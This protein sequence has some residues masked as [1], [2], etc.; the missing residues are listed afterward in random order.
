M[1]TLDMRAAE[2]PLPV[3]ASCRACGSAD[4]RSFF[5]SPAIPVNNAR[6]FEERADALRVPNGALELAFC[7]ACGF[8]QNPRFD[9]ALVRYD[10]SYEEQQS[11]SPTF[12]AFADGLV[13][14]IIERFGLQGKRVVEIGCGKGDFLVAICERGGNAGLGL[15]PTIAPDRL[16]QRTGTQLTLRREFFGE[17]TGLL[18]ADAVICR[19]TLEHIADVRGFVRAL[20]ASLAGSPHARI[21]FE[22]PDVGRVLRE[23]AFW[24]VYYE[25]CSYFT[26]D[27]LARLFRENGFT[28]DDAWLA[29]GDQYVMLEARINPDGAAPAGGSEADAEALAALTASYA[30]RVSAEMGRWSNTIRAAKDA[31]ERV[32]VWGS[33][34]KCVAFLSETGTAELVDAVVDINPHRQGRFLPSTG[35][36]VR[37]PESL[38]AAPPDLVVVMNEAYVSEITAQ[39]ASMGLKPQ[40]EAVG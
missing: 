5:S 24:D 21:F 33:G 6:V 4:L 38:T 20:R 11:F 36:Q 40:V 10:D 39:L 1:N 2:S 17:E 7:R 30:E 12:T 35:I 34:S 14:D 27:S 19:H 26:T 16:R 13:D 29:F 25:H 22:V 28:V 23:G 3:D 18:D 9:P 8:I 15:D 32:A 31:G 37:A